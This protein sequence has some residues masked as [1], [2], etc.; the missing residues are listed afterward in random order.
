MQLLFVLVNKFW[1][2]HDEDLQA[3]SNAPF[4][5]MCPST[6]T[7][8]AEVSLGPQR[9]RPVTFG[10]LTRDSWCLALFDPAAS[11]G[12]VGRGKGMQGEQPPSN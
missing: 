4:N 5:E 1:V 7:P 6:R 3:S 11:S 8:T 2:P 9:D 12:V 10:H